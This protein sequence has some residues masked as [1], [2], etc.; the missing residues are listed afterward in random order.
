MK[1]GSVV[2][3][4]GSLGAGKTTFAKGIGRALGIDEPITSPTFTILSVY[5]G[6]LVLNHF[7]LYR[8]SHPEELEMLGFSEILYGDGVTLIEWSDRADELPDDVIRVV[9]VIERDN[10]RTIR[11]EGLKE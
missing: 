10:S 9:I 2:T 6:A 4:E 8:I 5:E 7:D 3:L 1:S 11:I